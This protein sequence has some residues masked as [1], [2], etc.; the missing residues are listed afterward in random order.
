M[1]K[2]RFKEWIESNI[3]ALRNE[4]IA[5]EYAMPNVEDIESMAKPFIRIVQETKLCLGQVIVYKSRE[6]EFE[7]IQIE[8]EEMLLWKYF[9]N[10]NDDTDFEIILHPYFQTI[11]SGI[12][13]K[14]DQNKEK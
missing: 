9:E 14:N 11:K 12:K 6:M 5:T 7:V 1:I 3:E 13:P 2:Q 10:I 8:S 4:G